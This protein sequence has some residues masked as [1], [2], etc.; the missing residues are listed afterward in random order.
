MILLRLA[1]SQTNL[2]TAKIVD[3]AEYARRRAASSEK[4]SISA[5]PNL[6]ER[7]EEADKKKVYRKNLY[8]SKPFQDLNKDFKYQPLIHNAMYK[9]LS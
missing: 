3:A 5:A 7:G 8:V 4:L 1:E 9:N 2:P 6:E